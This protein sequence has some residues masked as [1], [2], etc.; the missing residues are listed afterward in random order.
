VKNTMGLN[1]EVIYKACTETEISFK[2]FYLEITYAFHPDAFAKDQ[3][4]VAFM[5]G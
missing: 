3:D 1:L 4:P 2:L 5:D